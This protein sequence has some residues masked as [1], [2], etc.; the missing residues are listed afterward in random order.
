VAK[1]ASKLLSEFEVDDLDIQEPRLENII[2][3]VFDN[4][5]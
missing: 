5:K 2:A 3:E 1:M 4:N